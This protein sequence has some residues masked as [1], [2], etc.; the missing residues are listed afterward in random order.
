MALVDSVGIAV[1]GPV[2]SIILTG[3]GYLLSYF[4]EELANNRSMLL[5]YLAVAVP[6]F[7]IGKNLILIILKYFSNKIVF[8]IK[9]ELEVKLFKGFLESPYAQI[10]PVD[11]G[12][13]T[14]KVTAEV[15]VV[16]FNVIQAAVVIATEVF[17]IFF[18]FSVM[19]IYDTA[20]FTILALVLTAAFIPLYKLSAFYQNKWGKENRAA[21]SDLYSTLEIGFG[22]LKEIRVY[23]ALNY[24][25]NRFRLE[26]RRV[27]KSFSLSNTLAMSS[28]PILETVIIIA[29]FV[30]IYFLV[31]IRGAEASTVT[32]VLGLY[33]VAAVRLLP[34]ASRLITSINQVRFGLHALNSVS[35]SL[36]ESDCKSRDV[37]AP[38]QRKV[39]R[40]L[41]LVD[42]SFQFGESTTRGPNLA[43]LNLRIEAGQYIG[44]VGES[45]SGKSTLVNLL[46]GL[47]K[48]TS[49]Q[50]LLNDEPLTESSLRAFYPSIGYVPQDVY[51]AG[52]SLAENIA[53]GVDVHEVNIERVRDLVMKV[54]LG[55]LLPGDASPAN[56]FLA[57]RGN[58]VSG[59]QRARIGLAR[60]LYRRPSLLILDEF[61]AG[62]DAATAEQIIRD[63]MAEKQSKLTVVMVSHQPRNF[64]G[65][66]ELWRVGDNGVIRVLNES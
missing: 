22:A 63:L 66:D 51:I 38:A 28:L 44:V 58:S 13:Q 12:K 62:L 26:T 42:V 16:T 49:G 61:T 53:F 10:A 46:L 64:I 23:Q 45:G 14:S 40:A 1:V 15:Q 47:L 25:L 55:S 48:P 21:N 24:Y 52:G 9:S 6:L 36:S 41:E 59:G 11:S 33:A 31:E 32:E 30:T 39:F 57:S 17:V 29:L 35:F 34:G 3:D 8:H 27:A 65:F 43:Y 7:F 2:L 4:P 5:K 19:F 56:V 60:A 50:I 18:L 54:G 20:L 37:E